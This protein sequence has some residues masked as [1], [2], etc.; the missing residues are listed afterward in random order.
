MSYPV[1]TNGGTPITPPNPVMPTTGVAWD[2][3]QNGIDLSGGY[4]RP[5]CLYNV[6]KNIL[7]KADS[8]TQPSDSAIAAEVKN[9]VSI[10]NAAAPHHGWEIIDN[11]DKVTSEQLTNVISAFGADT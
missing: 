7:L 2:S 4:K 3:Y 5:D 8:G 10:Y 11:P 1:P 6:A 9:L